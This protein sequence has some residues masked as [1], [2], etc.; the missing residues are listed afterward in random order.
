MPLGGTKLG[1]IFRTLELGDANRRL[2]AK[3]C[4]G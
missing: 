3:L 2:R 4:A 1:L